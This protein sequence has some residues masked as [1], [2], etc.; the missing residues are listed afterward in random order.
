MGSVVILSHYLY[1]FLLLTLFTVSA[2]AAPFTSGGDVLLRHDLQ[3]LTD[4]GLL[5]TPITAWPLSWPAIHAALE[6]GHPPPD[7]NSLLQAAWRRVA[8]RAAQ[9]KRRHAPRWQIGIAGT[10]D[11]TPWPGFAD[12]TREHGAAWGRGTWQTSHLAGNLQLTAVSSPDDGQEFRWDGSYGAI[13]AGNWVLGAGFID[14]WW[15]P[16]WEGSLILSSQ[17]RPPPAIFVQ[18]N[19]TTPFSWPLLKALGPWQFTFFTGRLEGD[20]SD[21]PHALFTGM[22]FN[23]R[24]TPALEIGLSRTSQWGGEGR[25]ETLRTFSNMLVGIDNATTA[26]TSQEAG[27]QLAGYDA[28]W[29]SPLFDLP[30]ALYGQAIGEDE[31]DGLPIKFFGLF[32][33]ETWTTWR[34]RG[35]RWHVEYADTTIDFFSEPGYGTVYRHHIYTAGYTHRGRG[36]GHS[37]GGDGRS[38]SLGLLLAASNGA[39]WRALLQTVTTQRGSP[40]AENQTLLKL[41]YQRPWQHWRA[42]GDVSVLSRSN[43]REFIASFHLE[44]DF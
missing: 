23:F 39:T 17:A 8:A 42:G 30:Y 37:I 20:R 41:S 32:G 2:S 1:P 24:P 7:N 34:D 40:S 27:N 19:F 18:R 11:P 43:D 38:T 3:V 21:V 28:R 12:L 14:R 25:P 15:G 26:D 31:A 22:R 9:E 36:L 13:L 4:H 29:V 44:A 16:G 33:I 6:Q 10:T 35:V 5:T